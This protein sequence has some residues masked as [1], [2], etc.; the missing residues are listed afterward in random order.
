MKGAAM[1]A[2][3]MPAWTIITLKPASEEAA[4]HSLRQAGYR[5]YLPRYRRIL[6]PHGSDRAGTPSMRPAI[7]G[8]LF[9][10]DWRGWPQRSISGVTGIMQWASRNA[11]LAD[12]IIEAMWDKERRGEYDDCRSPRGIGTT[13]D[14]L[15]IGQQVGIEIGGV[16]MLGSLDALDENNRAMLTVMIFGRPTSVE[17]SA[18]DVLDTGTDDRLLASSG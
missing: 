16:R 1:T 13:R 10:Q 17:V 11:T 3:E 12:T 2:S 14:D 4:E 7:P 6:R 5:V 8:Y 15:R 18:D 9:V